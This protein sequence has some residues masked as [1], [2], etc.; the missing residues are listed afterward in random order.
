MQALGGD[1]A[2]TFD[3]TV[4]YDDNSVYDDE[5]PAENGPELSFTVNNAKGDFTLSAGAIM[6]GDYVQSE[7]QVSTP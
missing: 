1:G 3:W 2:Y 7:L 6:Y 5:W 4:D